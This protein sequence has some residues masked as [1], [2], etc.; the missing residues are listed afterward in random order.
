MR[1]VLVVDYD[2]T[3]YLNDDDIKN[4]I[5]LVEKFM[6]L[7]NL[8]VIATGRSYADFLKKKIKYNIKYDYL[9]LN[10]GATILDNSDNILYNVFID[11]NIDNIKNTLELDK[12]IMSFCCS[13]LESRVDFNHKELTKIAVRYLPFVNISKI[14]SQ[15]DNNFSNIN[16][17][18]VSSNMLEIISCKINKSK[19]IKVLIKK[20][21]ID[22]N[23]VYTI[24]DSYTDIDMIK[25]F[26]GYA[27][28]NSIQNVKECAINE[29]KSVGNLIE[30]LLDGDKIKKIIR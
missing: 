7:G 15:L 22:K 8:F 2:K 26:K 20:L 18:L 3:F 11:E 29:Y 4:N 19:A 27:M 14:K 13:K 12:S 16:S 5:R 1:K 25:S 21:N 6:H 24:G 23:D 10:H 28:E 30:D 9:L 17:Y